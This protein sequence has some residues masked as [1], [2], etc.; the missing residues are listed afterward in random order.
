MYIDKTDLAW[1]RCEAEESHHL[2]MEL[3]IWF[4]DVAG[5]K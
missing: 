4:G 5:E 2:N 1:G 3:D